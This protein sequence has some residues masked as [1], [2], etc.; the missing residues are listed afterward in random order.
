MSTVAAGTTDGQ[1][2][3]Q[4]AGAIGVR[5]GVE[6]RFWA[7]GA[8]WLMGQ[9]VREALR[10]LRGMLSWQGGFWEG[11]RGRSKAWVS[12]HQGL[13]GGA[14]RGKV[15]KAATRTVVVIPEIWGGDKSWCH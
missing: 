15:V 11:A 8:A 1:R 12:R 6:G 14:S 7:G 10:L 9:E 2:G 4:G 5:G 13:R 3:E